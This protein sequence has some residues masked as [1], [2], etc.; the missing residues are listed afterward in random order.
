[1]MF[2]KKQKE[3]MDKYEIPENVQKWFFKVWFF[4]WTIT[5]VITGLYIAF[6]IY[7]RFGIEKMIVFQLTIIIFMFRAFF[8]R[9]ELKED[10]TL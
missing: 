3:I 1:M 9:Q 4:I 6:R 7:D 10:G 2:R 8:K 5:K